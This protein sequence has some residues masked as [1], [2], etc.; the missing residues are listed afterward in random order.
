MTAV[1]PDVLWRPSEQ[2]I[3]RAWLTRYQERLGLEFDDYR[4]LWRWSV[5]EL[6]DFW[7]SIVEIFEVR[8]S[9]PPTAVLGSRSMP[10]AE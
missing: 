1:E 8:F 7:R 5:D 2:R 4:D 6:D 3:E 10:G 9:S